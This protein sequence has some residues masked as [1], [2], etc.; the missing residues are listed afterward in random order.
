MNDKHP[1]HYID[2][3]IKAE[4][5]NLLEFLLQQSY[6]RDSL[7]SYYLEEIPILSPK[8]QTLIK[9]ALENK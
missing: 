1:E 5:V 6:I 8:I 7:S 2:L 4:N 9:S 3:A